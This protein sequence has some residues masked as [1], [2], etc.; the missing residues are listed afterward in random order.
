M[1][2][3]VIE[4]PYAG[5][6]ATNTRYARAALRDC[7]DRGEAPLASHLLI[8]QVLDDNVPDDRKRGIDAG[9]AWH[10]N[11]DAIVVYCDLGISRG[12]A[13]AIGHAR[14]HDIPVEFRSLDEW[15]G[16]ASARLALL[17][18]PL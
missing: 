17:G 18:D 2:K 11:A 16:V 8:T 14:G 6:V 3:V 12:M 13:A 15:H 9:L 4:S 7:L 1:R 10:A 5:D